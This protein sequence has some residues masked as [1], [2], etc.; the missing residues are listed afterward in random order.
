[1]SLVGAHAA[2]SHP[3]IA[4]VLDLS[5]VYCV[6]KLPP[7]ITLTFENLEIQRARRGMI[8]KVDLVCESV[9][10]AVVMRGSAVDAPSCVPKVMLF[11]PKQQLP[12]PEGKGVPAPL[13]EQA[14]PTRTAPC[15]E[16]VSWPQQ[17]LLCYNPA[18]QK[19][20]G[21]YG[22]LHSCA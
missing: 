17:H 15:S 19:S 16:S 1:M 2:G 11:D 9:G 6:L 14:W 21:T 12:R 22:V 13:T 4:A 20:I 18:I 5:Y 7:G 8:N 3:F 10:A